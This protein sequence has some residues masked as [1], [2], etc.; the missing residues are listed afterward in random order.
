MCRPTPCSQC[1]KTTWA[2]C[3]NHVDEVMREVPT[4]RR[5]ACARPP[6]TGGFLRSLFGR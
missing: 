1:G 3:G 4:G 2:G 5:C 6:A